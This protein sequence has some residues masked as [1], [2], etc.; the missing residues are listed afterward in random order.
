MCLA[1]VTPNVN[2]AG[3]GRYLK[4]KITKRTGFKAMWVKIE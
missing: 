4:T 3:H 2:C 1:N